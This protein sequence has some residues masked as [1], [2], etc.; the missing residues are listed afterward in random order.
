MGKEVR[1][2]GY[3]LQTCK[4]KIFFGLCKR[5]VKEL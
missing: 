4:I 1:K 3:K 2:Q 5:W